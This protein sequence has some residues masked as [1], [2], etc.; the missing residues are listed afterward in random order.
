[1]KKLCLKLFSVLVLFVLSFTVYFNSII[2]A[3]TLTLTSIG[4]LSTGGAMYPEWWYTGQNAQ[5]CGTADANATV[6]VS[7]DGSSGSTTAD[8]EGDW[9][10][11]TTTPTGDH[12][13]VITSGGESY[14][15]TLHAG[16][17]Y[18]PGAGGTTQT[19][20]ST[21]Q[22]PITGSDQIMILLISSGLLA[23]GYY[24]YKSK[25][26]STKSFEDSMLSD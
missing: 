16:Q 25:T 17:N 22:V 14:S 8:A 5:L 4:A 10:Y 13:I 20:Q 18:V 9:C 23:M 11:A 1:M 24:L 7:V 3:A 21:S 15:F 12:A 26:N 6:T 2:L 19:T